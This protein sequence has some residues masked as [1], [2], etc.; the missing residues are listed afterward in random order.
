[1]RGANPSSRHP[2]LVSVRHPE[3]VSGS[4]LRTARRQWRKPKLARQIAPSRIAFLNQIDLPL[5]APVLELL[6]TR[7]GEVHGAEELEM[8][9]AVDAVSAGEPLDGALA[10][11]MKPRE[12]VGSHADIQ[13]FAKATRKDVGAG[14]KVSLHGQ[15]TARRW[16]LKQVQGDEKWAKRGKSRHAELVSA[17]MTGCDIEAAG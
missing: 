3:L 11:L 15:E 14:L 8:D 13:R 10:V 16:T 5:P 7:N 6:L 1:M 4:I 9:E 2:E 17:S 12:K